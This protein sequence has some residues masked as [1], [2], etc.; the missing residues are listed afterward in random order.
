MKPIGWKFKKKTKISGK[1]PQ[2]IDY[3]CTLLD[4][5]LR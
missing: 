3:T 1:E 2:M 4:V 5:C